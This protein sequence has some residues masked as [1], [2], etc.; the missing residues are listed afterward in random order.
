MPQI[1]IYLSEEEN[2]KVEELSKKWK[3]SKM[4]TVKRIILDFIEKEEVKK[5]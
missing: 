2:N 4:E 5:K 3:L 1:N